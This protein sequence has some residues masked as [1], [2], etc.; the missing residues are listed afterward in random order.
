MSFFEHLDELRHRLKV[1][2]TFVIGFF[3]FFLVFSVMPVSLGSPTIP[4]PVPAFLYDDDPIANKFFRALQDYYTGGQNVTFFPSQLWDGVIVQFKVAFFLSVIAASPV[5]AYEFAKFIGPALKA[6]E[7]RLI[8]RI[9]LPVFGLFAFGVAVAH[10]II[11]PFT[12]RFLLGILDRLN[13]ARI[14]FIDEFVTF[15]TVFL[16]AFGL[17][18]ELPVMMYGLSAVGI[19]KAD[20]WRRYWRIVVIGI[21]LFAAFITPDASGITMILVA[22]PM[23]C[24]Y[25]V[26][27][28]AIRRREKRLSRAKSS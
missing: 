2:A 19:V 21:F 12:F 4:V 17:A 18:F 16:V 25:G 5:I 24:L 23:V 26:G 11:L 20:F 7:K 28:L 9:A 10:L 22:I 6:S 15:V 3:L 8:V 27:Y 13:V 1:V 14:L